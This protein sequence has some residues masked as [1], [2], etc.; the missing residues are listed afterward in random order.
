MTTRARVLQSIRETVRQTI[1]EKKQDLN[2]DGKNDFEDVM[3]ARMKASGE[4]E[5]TAVKK[6]E[7]A[8]AKA[9]SKSQ[10]KV[11]ETKLT[12]SLLR[13]LLN[14]ELS[15]SNT[16]RGMLSE[17]E[18]V[19]AAKKKDSPGE[20]K[21]KSVGGT[22]KMD[23]KK[24]AEIDKLLSKEPS[25]LGELLNLL[26]Q[27]KQ[28]GLKNVEGVGN[29]EVKSIW[30]TVKSSIKAAAGKEGKLTKSMSDKAGKAMGG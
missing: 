29:Q 21:G 6:G 24:Q 7:K 5:E 15:E 14:K 17:L 27:L 20:D 9:K 28:T 19:G 12:S 13:D 11:T 10:S 30:D 16:R 23:P 1:R 4:D 2:K 22:E 8:A 18:T 3:I 26:G 25:S